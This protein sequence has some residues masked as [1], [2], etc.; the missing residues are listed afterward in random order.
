MGTKIVQETCEE[1]EKRD[2][3]ARTLMADLATRRMGMIIGEPN[4]R[5]AEHARQIAKDTAGKNTR[6][7]DAREEILRR[8]AFEG[9][10]SA[11][12]EATLLETLEQ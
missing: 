10:S 3:L 1:Q 8:L 7:E 4:H 11:A 12:E 2:S 5:W 6:G 9:A